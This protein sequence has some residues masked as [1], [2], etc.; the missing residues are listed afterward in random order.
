MSVQCVWLAAPG[1]W[2]GALDH[3]IQGLQGR[4]RE[5]QQ[6]CHS[7]VRWL[8]LEGGLVLAGMDLGEFD[9]LRQDAREVLQGA[10][11]G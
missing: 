9:Q 5:S 11:D 2:H 1:E 6:S 10:R 8:P 4:A 7:W 3:S